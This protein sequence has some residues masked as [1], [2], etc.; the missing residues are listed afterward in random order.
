KNWTIC[1][2]AAPVTTRSRTVIHP[3]LYSPKTLLASWQGPTPPVANGVPPSHL[4][5]R[6]DKIHGGALRCRQIY[7]GD[8]PRA[9]C[10]A[11]ARLRSAHA[12]EVLLAGYRQGD[13]RTAGR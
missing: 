11:V 12:R 7:A 6:L 13:V 1:S 2:E 4:P 8:L 3:Y 10:R 9:H 5:Y